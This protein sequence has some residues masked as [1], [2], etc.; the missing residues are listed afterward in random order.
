MVVGE[1]AFQATWPWLVAAGLLAAGVAISAWRTRTRSAVALTFGL[2]LLA[3][4]LMVSAWRGWRVGSAPDAVA[5]AAVEQAVDTRDRTLA[6]AVAGA[7][8]VGLNA[9]QRTAGAAPGEAPELRDLLGSGPL[10]QGLVV[11]GGDTVIA[12]AGPQRTAPIDPTL[13]AALVREPFAHL[14]VIT[15]A[16]AGARSAQVTLLLDAS[17]A[18]PASGASLADAARG[19]RNVDWSWGP[20]AKQL[21]FRSVAE[22]LA[23]VASEMV[24]GAP[25]E[26][27]LVA[28]EAVLARWLAVL[29]LSLLALVVLLA[30]AP[31]MAR[32]VA[33]VLPLWVMLR[34][35][36]VAS[37]LGPVAMPAL[38]AAATLLMIAVV[39]WRRHPRRA[40]IGL[41]AS[42]ILLALAPPLVALAGWEM[43]A[44]VGDG[45]L[46]SWFG[47]QAV[48]ALTTAAYLAIASAPLRSDGDE[49][50]DWRP[51]AAALALA[52]VAGGIGIEAW[53]PGVAVASRPTGWDTTWFWYLPCWLVALG[54]MVPVTTPR[55]RRVA[56]VTAASLLAALSAWGASLD[57]RTRLA[58]AD[59]DRLDLV[60][61]S[62]SLAELDRFGA[63]VA[64][65]R[66]HDLD[67]LYAMWSGSGL[68]AAE[69]P[70]QFAIWAD[71]TVMDWV[72]LDSMA[73][74]WPELAAVVAAE[75]LG[76]RPVPLV[77]G[78][79]RH[80]LMVV[81]VG[82]DTT[83]SIQVGPR[84]EFIQPTR[85]GRLVGWRN[86]AEPAYRLVA[87]PG[88]G[89]RADG[90]FR[91]VGRQISID[92]MV[93]AGEA[94]MLV[95][96][97]VSISPPRPFAVRAALTVMLDVALILL[98]WWLVERVLGFA[99]AGD[100]GVF[101]RSYRRTV[102]AALMAFFV[103]PAA[104]FTLWAALRL[105]QDVERQRGGDVARALRDI[106]STLDSMPW[107]LENPESESLAQVSYGV[108][109]E[110]AVY[111]RARL[112]ASSTPLMAHLGLL[113]PVVDPALV[114]A[115]ASAAPTTIPGTAVRVGVD[116]TSLPGVVVAA[117]LPGAD[118]QLERDQIDLALLLLLASLGATFAA[119]AVAGAVARALGQ[120]I[121]ALR[122]RAIA[123]GRREPAP[124][125]RQTL[126]E[127]EPVFGAITQMERD[128]GES[129]ARLEDETARTARIVAWGEMAR[130]VAHEIKNPLTPMRLGLQHLTRLARD[131]RP[132]LPQQ[133]A[134][135]AEKLL[136][137]IDRLDRIAR[138]FARYGTP[139][140]RNQGPLEPVVLGDVC[141]EIAA[142]FAVA[143]AIPVVLVEG[144]SREPVATRREE[145]IQV[146]LNLLDNARQAGATTVGLRM[147]EG[148][149]VV[150]DNGGGIPA[151]QLERIF[152]PT[153]S[154]TT[155]GTGLGLAIVRRLVE[156]W[157]GTVR[158]ES[159][160][161]EGT[162]FTVRFAE[163]TRGSV[164][165]TP[166][167][168][169]A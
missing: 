37:L 31:P 158:A 127:F 19:W 35:G 144:A 136:S 40:P 60:T 143:D 111:R 117:A 168:L 147:A 113:G 149:L 34:A 5:R 2:W 134:E 115:G 152:E 61:D 15:T 93:D 12:V 81:P 166:P 88:D 59:I 101:R 163:P 45:G 66:I 71:T 92:R 129:E 100:P 82:G 51:G 118:A 87:I 135:T 138:S 97:T 85:F 126:A 47:W 80:H 79:G 159:S 165:S 148:Q 154:T 20:S 90:L 140:E 160:A 78:G 110:V 14:L 150:T 108:G 49:T 86:P 75:G 151:D 16:G 64:A 116:A 139:P 67:S 156:G 55:M 73:T 43:A 84:S 72:A 50:A 119:V 112:A 6:S 7:R 153:F 104:T 30:G 133:M 94:P 169:D 57:T 42:I 74:T 121:E 23:G 1:A 13:A 89:G 62:V 18:L 9:L 120:P 131:Q 17:G 161:G 33:L 39:L 65:A 146:L 96:A 98:A 122:R 25:P 70:V 157:G 26:A 109:A 125:L 29:A 46:L 77:R 124:P 48:L 3:A 106:E 38:L 155:S 54:A 91:R 95:R 103:V 53:Q 123:I 68:R 128:L 83:V 32:A 142:L 145:L 99:R 52:L 44:R 137:E 132:E 24:P 22:A 102:T 69:V 56:L 41:S 107:V 27:T 10:E 58:D 28:R 8:Q 63:E 114:R 105:R 76:S 21:G 164:G 141:R 167:R 130:Q 162:A 11:L 4:V 36:V